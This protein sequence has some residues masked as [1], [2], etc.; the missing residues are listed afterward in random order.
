MSDNDQQQPT[1]DLAAPQPPSQEVDAAM[2]VLLKTTT[3]LRLELQQTSLELA[4]ILLE[5][6]RSGYELLSEANSR[7]RQSQLM[8][9]LSWLFQEQKHT[10]HLCGK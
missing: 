4:S 8:C 7:I 9:Q 1:L 10:S 2:E 6:G 3:E 5:K